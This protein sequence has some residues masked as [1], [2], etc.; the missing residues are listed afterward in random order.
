MHGPALNGRSAGGLTS[1]HVGLT[2]LASS[3]RKT[4]AGW[5]GVAAS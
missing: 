2:T 5:P 1:A 3:V 4:W